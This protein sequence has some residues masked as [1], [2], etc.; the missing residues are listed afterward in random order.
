MS[1]IEEIIRSAR[2]AGASDVHLAAGMSPKMRIGGELFSMNCSRLTAADMLDIL[3]GI[4]PE[5]LRDR[6]EE[7]G[8]HAFS[9]TLPQGPL[10]VG[11]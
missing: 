1:A 10:L 2:E 7:K 3:I 4:M 8:G 9:F 11:L 6:F 5:A